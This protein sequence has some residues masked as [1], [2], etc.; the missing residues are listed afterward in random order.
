MK[1]IIE[2]LRGSPRTREKTAIGNI[3]E[4]FPRS[5]GVDGENVLLGDDA[6]AVCRNG[7]YLLL[8][9]EGVY[10]PLLKSN[11]YLAG[12]TSVLTN[13][14]DVYAMGGRP[15]AILDV[16]SPS[17]PEET[18]RTLEGIRDNARRYG[19]PVVGG[20][21]GSA[22]DAPALAVF[23]LGEAKRLLSSFGAR[24]GDDL[25]LAVGIDGRFHSGFGFWDSSSKLP[26]DKAVENLEI[27]PRLAEDELADAARD[28]SMSG[29][30]GSALML[31]ECSGKGAEI[32]IDEFTPPSGVGLIDWLLAFPSYG[33]IFSLR[34]ENTRKVRKIFRDAGIFCEK[35]G[36]VRPD[37]KVYFRDRS[38]RRE[39]FWDLSRGFHMGNGGARLR[40]EADG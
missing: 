8:A 4:F 15:L 13:V 21:M 35:I 25:A 33:F 28:V 12:R 1:E 30:I 37:P 11:P 10:P 22:T 2:A 32:L 9:A 38:G 23:V 6:A 5:A 20:H 40:E 3:W 24:Q 19:I 7:S 29:A 31:L 39:L 34:P 14:N 16:L 27:L 18:A 36:E 17:G 26:A